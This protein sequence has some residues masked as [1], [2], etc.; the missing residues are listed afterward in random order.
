MHGHGFKHE[1]HRNQSLNPFKALSFA[2]AFIFTSPCPRFSNSIVHPSGEQRTLIRSTLRFSM[3][4]KKLP[5]QLNSKES[6]LLLFECLSK[7]H[8]LSDQRSG[9]R[10][11]PFFLPFSHDI[12]P[13]DCS[14]SVVRLSERSEYQSAVIDV[15]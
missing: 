6:A 13:P 10:I 4:L 2:D 8:P 11:W 14:S 3:Q 1:S 12:Q 15:L 5:P 7:C 9:Y